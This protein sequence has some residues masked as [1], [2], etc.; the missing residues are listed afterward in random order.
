[1]GA[2]RLVV[3]AFLAMVT[4]G[5]VGT[6]RAAASGPSACPP[7]GRAV[8][9]DRADGGHTV[10]VGVKQEVQLV[11]AGATLRWS[12]LRQLAPHVLRLR[13]RITTDGTGSLKA[14]YSAVRAGRTTLQATGAPRCSP[15]K[16]CPQFMLLWRVQ[17]VVS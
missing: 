16:A 4:L 12:G 6:P 10:H 15:G 9:V 2:A 14:S 8:C 17:V 13:G 1:M 5:S 7:G 3:A 11:L